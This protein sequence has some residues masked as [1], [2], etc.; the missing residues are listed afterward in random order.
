VHE[1][2]NTGDG[3]AKV[4]ATYIVEQGQALAPPAK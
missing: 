1:G 2:I 4:L 3:K